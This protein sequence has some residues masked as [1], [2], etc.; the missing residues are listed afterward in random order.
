V[1]AL[2]LCGGRGTRL[3]AAVEK[4]LFEV[5]GVPM[6]DRVLA[7]LDGS[8]VGEVYPVV[9][10]HAPATREHLADRPR[11]D[12]HGE[13]YV[14]DLEFALA[15]DRVA[16]PVLTVAADLPLLEPDAVDA[17]LD[18][19]DAGSLAVYVPASLK[20]ALGTSVDS[21]FERDGRE[22]AATGANVVGD[23]RDETYVVEDRRLAVNVN[24]RRDAAVAEA[25]L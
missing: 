9:S 14:A 13:G 4:P 10:P 20:R 18:A 7:A 16:V 24:R 1:D 8:R 19:H 11:I 22:L 21:T 3:D 2:L 17:V 6:I 5:G 23:G 12:A 15:D 25:W